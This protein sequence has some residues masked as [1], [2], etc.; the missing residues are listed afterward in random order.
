MIVSDVVRIENCPHT[1]FVTLYCNGWAGSPISVEFKCSTV[2]P[3]VA[4]P[5]DSLKVFLE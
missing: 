2:V 4:A 1:L 3:G 5:Q